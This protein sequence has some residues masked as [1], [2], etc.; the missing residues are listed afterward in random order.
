MGW[1]QWLERVGVTNPYPKSQNS[2][3]VPSAVV[4]IS[5]GTLAVSKLLGSFNVLLLSQRV[6]GEAD[7]V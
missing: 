7:L 5:W 2:S 6:G 4:S 1:D 3:A